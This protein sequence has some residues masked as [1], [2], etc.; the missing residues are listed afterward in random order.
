MARMTVTV[1]DELLDE[2]KRLSGARTKRETIEAALRDLVARM[3]RRRIAS[4]AGTVEIE[5]THEKLRRWREE[6]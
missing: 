3:R 1:D 2:A 4:H 5:L 6:R